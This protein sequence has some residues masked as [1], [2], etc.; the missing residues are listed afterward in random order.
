MPKE[1]R[2]IAVS[3]IT[4]SS[5]RQYE[6]GF[7]R[8]WKFCERK[9]IDSLTAGIP[10]VLVF[11]ASE[12]ENGASY[13]TINSFRSAIALL[14]GPQ[15]GH[16][17]RIKRF[18]KGTAKQRP[19]APKYESTWDPKVV[20]DLFSR[21]PSN[22]E[23]SLE[24]LSLKLITLLALITGHRPQTLS[25]IDIRNINRKENM[26]E[27]K[28]P[29]RIKTSGINRKQPTLILPFY[30]ENEKICVAAALQ[31]YLNSSKKVRETE[32]ALFI[33]YKKPYKTVGTQTLSRWTKSVLKMSGID[34]EIFSAYSTRHA[35]TSAACK[36]GIS[37]D[38]IKKTAGWTESS[39]TFT[40]FY[41]L[42]ITEPKDVF[43][44]A[45]LK[46]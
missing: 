3:S 2:D 42:E 37:I 28:I 29:G 44:R 30:P 4:A 34:T 20:L 6:T 41:N 11:L 18:C 16:D 17:E 31:A 15:V 36:K 23:L 24:K 19:P 38:I 5:L 40:K 33:S 25:L 46:S 32:T 1:A 45:I 9:K 43:A 8:W 39:K 10:D 35:A 12:F 21:W 13:G 26:L 27:I 22:N 7:K 14:L